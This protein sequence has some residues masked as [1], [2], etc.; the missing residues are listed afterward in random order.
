MKLYWH[1]E[2]KRRVPKL[3][4]RQQQQRWA[5]TCAS[6]AAAR[7]RTRDCWRPQGPEA[8]QEADD[9]TIESLNYVVNGDPVGGDARWMADHLRRA[10]TRLDGG[11]YF[12]ADEVSGA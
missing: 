1:H 11:D 4:W 5:W 12:N 3:C 8:T 2:R 6:A 9:G 10:A 7:E